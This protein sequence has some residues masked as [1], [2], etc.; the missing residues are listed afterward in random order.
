MTEIWHFLSPSRF[1]TTTA[2]GPPP[3]PISNP[4]PIRPKYTYLLPI[5]SHHAAF[6]LRLHQQSHQCNYHH[7]TP[8]PGFPTKTHSI[9]VTKFNFPQPS[10]PLNLLHNLSSPTSPSHPSIQPR[11][12]KGNTVIPHGQKLKHLVKVVR[13]LAWVFGICSCGLTSWTGWRPCV[14]VSMCRSI[15]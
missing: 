3:I 8:P 6:I 11:C 13:L 9:Q 2:S 4:C 15:D 5:P 1:Q 14:H 7:K 10:K 12:V